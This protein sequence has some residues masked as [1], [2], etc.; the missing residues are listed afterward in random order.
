MSTR[1]IH[2]LKFRLPSSDVC[3]SVHD[4]SVEK[5][6]KIYTIFISL[7]NVFEHHLVHFDIIIPLLHEDK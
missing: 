7:L 4:Y 2:N 1:N 6:Q 3:A 5:G